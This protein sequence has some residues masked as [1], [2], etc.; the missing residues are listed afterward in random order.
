MRMG[1]RSS[2][3][4]LSDDTGFVYYG[5]IVS[6]KPQAPTDAD[7]VRWSVTGPRRQVLYGEHMK[8]V[9]ETVADRVKSERADAMGAVD[10]SVNLAEQ[11]CG[12]L[13]A[14]YVESPWLHVDGIDPGTLQEINDW[15]ESAQLWP[16]MDRCQRDT[17]GLRE[18]LVHLDVVEGALIP[19]L[20]F[21]D[22]VAAEAGANPSMPTKIYETRE[23]QVEGKWS[24]FWYVVELTESGTSFRV[25]SSLDDDAED[26]SGTFK[27]SS[28]AYQYADGTGFLPYVM[29]RAAKHSEMWSPNEWAGLFSA[30]LQICV[31]LTYFDHGMLQASWAQ[32]WMANGRVVGGKTSEPAGVPTIN[33]NGKTPSVARHGV[34]SDPAVLLKFESSGDNEHPIQV[35]Q[36]VP[37]VDPGQVLGAAL[38]Y[39]RNALESIGIDPAAVVRTTSDP[40]SGI[41][42][43]VS[44]EAQREAQKQWFSLFRASDLE[45]VRKAIAMRNRL[46]P[47]GPQWPETGWRITY[48]SLPPTEAE[49]SAKQARLTDQIDRGLASKVDVYMEL[50][51]GV[52]RDAATKKLREIAAENRRIEAG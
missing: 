26:V 28:D 14:M 8:A 35:G 40:R 29:Y 48:R 6:G 42:L 10:L 32:R 23:R 37:A 22:C 27:V 50:H 21:P 47:S 25:L 31:F 39:L 4:I 46:A 1:M 11:T 45:L 19:R 12:Q 18:M 52:S 43:T 51:P 33:G 36:F 7:A 24:W 49:L 9:Q 41:A 2:A 5:F 3:T 44:R 20:V 30:T 13:S 38:S 16:L 15:F 34:T 17:L